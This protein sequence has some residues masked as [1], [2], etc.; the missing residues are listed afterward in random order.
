MV[1]GLRHHLAS[2]T[3]I[4]IEVCGSAVVARLRAVGLE[5]I[6]AL[7]SHNSDSVFFASFVRPLVCTMKHRIRS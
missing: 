5:A 2:S 4:K 1:G 7:F 3:S 6:G